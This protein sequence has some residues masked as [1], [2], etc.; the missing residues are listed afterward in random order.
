MT[1][2]TQNILIF[3]LMIILI[4][5]VVIWFYVLNE[6]KLIINTGVSNYTIYAD[7]QPTLCAK[8]PCEIELK[9]GSYQIRFVKEG[10]IE[11]SSPTTI[12]RGKT[13]AVNFEAKKKM[14]I[15]PVETPIGAPMEHQLGEIPND[16]NEDDI[17]ASAWN[18]K[19]DKFL[20]L[21]N[22]DSRL[23]IREADGEIKLITTLKNIP[24]PVDFYWSSDD[25]YILA[26][27]E[28]DIYFIEIDMGSRKKQVMDFEPTQI[29]WSPANDF[30]LLNDKNRSLYKIGWEDQENMQKM[31]VELSLKESVWIS[32][33][34]L[35]TYKID[36]DRNETE[37][38]TYDPVNL[39]KENF[40]QK[41]DF[42]IDKIFYNS[43][44]NI[45]YFHHEREKGWYE[46]KM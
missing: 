10:Y 14:E 21:D 4:G 45:V 7:N 27:K 38:W 42:P 11:A 36:T 20:F 6:G 9:V 16:L 43:G 44:Q 32:D 2:K 13:S 40:A 23:K 19:N 30:L 15:T 46:M 26:N 1:N 29:T 8:D 37:I 28:T 24:S 17:I 31:D 41:F 39:T 22:S 18:Y 35:L 25:K 12:V 33:T 3:L 34:T 5:A